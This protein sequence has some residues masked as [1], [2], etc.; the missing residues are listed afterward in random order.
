MILV[1]IM[2]ST[3]E[4]KWT[5]WCLV[6]CCFG[7]HLNLSVDYNLTENIKIKSVLG[8]VSVILSFYY[9]IV[10]IE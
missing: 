10:I 4:S 9:F 5:Y 7:Q 6:C 1:S 3:T 2:K 8:D